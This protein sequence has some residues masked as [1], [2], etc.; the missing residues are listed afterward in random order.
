MGAAG[1][2]EDRGHAEGE[3]LE[4]GDAVAGETNPILLVAHRDQDAASFE[5][6]MN[7]AMKIQANRQPTSKKYRMILA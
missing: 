4:I 5:C 6:R 1:R 3:D 2:G 7:W